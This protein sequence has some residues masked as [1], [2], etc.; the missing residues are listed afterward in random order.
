MS[1]HL[2]KATKKDVKPIQEI[3]KKCLVLGPI[4]ALTFKRGLVKDIDYHSA[5]IIKNKRTIVA[6]ITVRH[7]PKGINAEIITLAVKNKY[8]NKGLGK[9]LV[10]FTKYVMQSKKYKKLKVGTD[11]R[12]NA[13]EFYKKMNFKLTDKDTW[14]AKL[15]YKIA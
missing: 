9:W 7:Y 12:Y 4:S 11:L 5:Y 13:I 3:N 8:R 10:N 1:L 2:F 6:V 14:S 15:E